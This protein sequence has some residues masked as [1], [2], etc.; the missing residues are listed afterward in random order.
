[1]PAHECWMRAAWLKPAGRYR[2]RMSQ[3][4]AAVSASPEYTFS[5]PNLA[6][7]T[8]VAGI[9]VEGDAHSGELV[10]HR[11]LVKKDSTQPN[12]RQVHLI[13]QELFNHVGEQGHHVAAGELGENITTSGI[14]LL[15]LPTG[16]VLQIGSQATIQLTGLRNPC[17][18]IDDFQPGLM[19]LLRYRDDGN[20]VRICGVMAVVLVGGVVR[21]GDGIT[22]ELPL[23]PHHPLI[24]I[25]D[26]H[27]PVQF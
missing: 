13:H 23:E 1:M 18:Q 20:I 24:Y 8:L 16:T 14:D 25:A 9:G 26:S 5:K 2:L 19:K 17:H 21:P 10:K 4:V 11:Y 27:K 15:A 7:I 3:L 6:S 12:L 22:V